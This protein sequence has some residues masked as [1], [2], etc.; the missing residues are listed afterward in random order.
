MID[1]NVELKIWT[2]VAAMVK[3]IRFVMCVGGT[4]YKCNWIGDDT[5]LMVN[6]QQA[7][8]YGGCLWQL[9]CIRTELHCYSYQRKLKWNFTWQHHRFAFGLILLCADSKCKIASMLFAHTFHYYLFSCQFSSGCCCRCCYLCVSFL[10]LY[11]T[12]VHE[13]TIKWDIGFS[14]FSKWQCTG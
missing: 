2:I 7:N 4:L 6:K 3:E 13:Y 9:S 8:D 12:T 5:R 10:L 1:A 11:S 14:P